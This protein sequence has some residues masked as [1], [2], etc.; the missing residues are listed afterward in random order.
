MA[1]STALTLF[2]EARPELN[3]LTTWFQKQ[4]LKTFPRMIENVRTGWRSKFRSY[5]QRV[6][7]ALSAPAITN[8]TK[9]RN[10]V[11]AIKKQIK[12]VFNKLTRN[13]WMHTEEN[14][15]MSNA[16]CDLLMDL[17][18]FLAED[19]AF[20]SSL[21]PKQADSVSINLGLC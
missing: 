1:N 6:G 9:P 2:M 18:N 12:S 5:M 20:R 14:F 15:C 17:G 21:T 13:K 4:T 19:Q 8:L 16:T 11:G 3:K 7:N 10:V